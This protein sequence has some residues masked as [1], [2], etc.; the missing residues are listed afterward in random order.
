MTK[1]NTRCT[2]CNYEF[3]QGELAFS[4][5]RW[6]CPRCSSDKIEEILG[7][8]DGI[9]NQNGTYVYDKAKVKYKEG[10]HD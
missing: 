2:E 7:A 10:P 6:V 1:I 4:G 5:S 8:D 3:E 9:R